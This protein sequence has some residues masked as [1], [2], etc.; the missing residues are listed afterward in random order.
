MTAESA[1]QTTPQTQWH[2]LLGKLLEELLT[3]VGIAV[4]TGF[5][6]MTNP[7]EADVLLLRREDQ[8][9]WTA[10]Q[11]ARLPDGVRHTAASHIILEFK[12]TESVNLSALQQ[13]IGYDNFYRRSN[14]LTEQAVQPFL[15][16]SRQPNGR[17][18]ETF[19]YQE[20]KWAGVYYSQNP[21]LAR[22]PI[23]SLNA[24]SDAEHN[25]FV[26]CFAS[27]KS[28]KRRAF[29]VLQT[30]K[31]LSYS[32]GIYWF[33]LNLWR[34][35]FKPKKGENDMN[36]QL[37]PKD[38]QEM[39]DMWGDRFLDIAP[40]EKMLSRLT[41]EERLAGLEPEERLAGLEPEERLAGLEPEERLA[42]LTP[43][44][45]AKIEAYLLQQKRQRDDD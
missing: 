19:G 37:S 7:P 20:S 35:W 42:G 6:I 32:P 38:F 27:R 31:L 25:A 15:L 21:M 16:S 18:L 36:V 5:P 40:P 33:I 23:L 45:L 34:H 3:P 9:K 30:E 17:F 2:R 28:E 43:E 11:Y 39:A 1:R 12:Y 10:D 22:L 44:D 8:D 41:L 24:L 26:K 29:A 4:L 14:Q 13:A